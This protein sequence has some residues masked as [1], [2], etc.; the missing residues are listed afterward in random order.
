[1]DV[2]SRYLIYGLI[3]P[4]NGELRYV[5][6]SLRGLIRPK[7]RHYAHCW[8]WEE[9]L[10]KENLKPTIVILEELSEESQLNDAEISWIA[11]KRSEGVRLTNMT[12]GGEGVKN[13][14]LEVREKQRIANLGNKNG[15]GHKYV[16]SEERKKQVG[17]R[18]RGKIE[19]VET[20]L[21]KSISHLGIKRTTEWLTN[22]SLAQKGKNKIPRIEILCNFCQKI[23][24]LRKTDRRTKLRR[25]FCNLSCSSSQRWKDERC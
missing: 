16:M 19:S 14:P 17:N 22:Q 2:V 4:R 10:L 5:G 24:I 11:L 21:K 7:E 13:P 23:V 18:H 20:R 25:V 9:N 15:L 1:M 8:S 12:D 6:Q 3:D